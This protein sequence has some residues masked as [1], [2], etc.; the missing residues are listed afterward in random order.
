LREL[1]SPGRSGAVFYFSH[2]M[3][4]LIKSVAK[5][6][7][8]FLRRMMPFYYQHVMMTEHT[9]ICLFFGLMTVLPDDNKS[10]GGIGVVVMPNMLDTVVHEVYDLKG[11]E[12]GRFTKEKDKE[13]GI[14]NVVQK[15]LDCTFQIFLPSGLFQTAK[16]VIHEDVKFLE[17]M[18]IMDYSMLLGLQRLEEGQYE[19]DEA[20]W[21]I[22]EEEED[23]TIPKKMSI[24]QKDLGG[25]CALRVETDVNGLYK[26]V[27][28]VIAFF[29]IIDILQTYDP[30]K[31][32]EHWLKRLWIDRHAVSVTD[33]RHYAERF[34]QRMIG[35][36]GLFVGTDEPPEIKYDE[37][38]IFEKDVNYPEGRRSTS[39]RRSSD[40]ASEF[41]RRHSESF[42]GRGDVNMTQLVAAAESRKRSQTDPHMGAA[43]PMK[44]GTG[45]VA[46]DD[47]WPADDGEESSEGEEAVENV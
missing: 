4:Y 14:A 30:A 12:Y 7:S 27:E 17:S 8:K 1:G 32:S 9:L 6:E 35:P 42:G 45:L 10:H 5:K 23:D 36:Q 37:T 25:V 15:D 29:G 46:N 43:N 40:S 28:P 34:R 3:K 47:E 41:R 13:K 31:F 38:A 21:P 33:P 26:S 24:F 19:I 2:D 20:G 44:G 18:H 11:S 39:H 22:V 16:E